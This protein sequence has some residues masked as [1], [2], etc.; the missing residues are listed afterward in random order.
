M[1]EIYPMQG[2]SKIPGKQ[3]IQPTM[4]KITSIYFKIALKVV[5]AES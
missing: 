1:Q 2:I 5:V 4:I 3:V